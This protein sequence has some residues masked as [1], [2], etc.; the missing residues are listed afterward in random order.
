MRDKL[1]N[2]QARGETTH[3][4]EIDNHFSWK[5]KHL[6]VWTGYAN[7]G[8][9]ALE[10]Q[11]LLLK[12][13]YCGWKHIIFS[14]EEDTEQFIFDLIEAL[15]G[16]PADPRYD[17]CMSDMQFDTAMDL[18]NEHFF[19]IESESDELDQILKKAEYFIRKNGCDTL[20][21]DPYNQITHEYSKAE[22]EDMYIGRF[23]TRLK[24][25]AKKQ[26]VIKNTKE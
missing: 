14:P 3:F 22:R 11:M 16:L 9:S 26:N 25:F 12:S 6:N 20:T 23:M 5:K 2:G 8:K 4:K 7:E 19:F 10:K 24:K 18:I 21:L 1:H 13:V 15:I 17:N